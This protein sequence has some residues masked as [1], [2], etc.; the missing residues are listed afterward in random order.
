MKKPE[1]VVAITGASG[2]IYGLRLLE[3]FK[4]SGYAATH[5]IVSKT[6]RFIMQT[7]IDSRAVESARRLADRFYDNEDLTACIASGS[8]KTKGMIIAPCSAKT[9]SAV[10]HGFS[11]NL[12]S[13]AADV[14]LKERRRL[15]LLFRETPLNLA[16]IENMASVTRMGGVVLPPVTAFYHHPASIDEIVNHCVGKAVDLFFDEDHG[17]YQKWKGGAVTHC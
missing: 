4:Q 7:E 12:I 6:A 5:L 13:R 11:D 8:Y 3:F 14:T 16:H 10:A 1:I 2:A 17:L 15:V 9:L